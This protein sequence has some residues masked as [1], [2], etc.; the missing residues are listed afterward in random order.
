MKRIS[1]AAALG[2]LLTFGL[3]MF[4]AGPAGGTPPHD[5]VCPTTAGWTGHFP[6]NNQHQI[7]VTAP[8]GL[9]IAEV[10][11]KAGS[12]NQGNGP[13]YIVFDPP[14]ATVTFVHSSGKEISHYSLRKVP[15]PTTTTTAPPTTTTTPPTTA[16]T[17]PT[18][19]TTATTTPPTTGTVPSTSLPTVF[20]DPT[21]TPDPT[22]E[23]GSVVLARTG[24][25]VRQ[26][27]AVAAAIVAG[28]IAARRSAARRRA[29]LQ[30]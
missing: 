28:G 19:Q 11:V 20:V 12:V 27:A 9:L 3:V 7:T 14:V 18:T 16:T 10:C 15:V 21:I 8:P 24:A 30:E 6:G 1:T 22:V 26:L 29:A 2:L 23:T 17:T 13:E 5:G 25:D 4:T